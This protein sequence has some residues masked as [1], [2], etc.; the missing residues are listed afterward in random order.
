[1][2]GACL[3]TPSTSA[4]GGARALGAHHS[5]HH[6]RPQYHTE[7]ALGSLLNVAEMAWGQG[8]DL[9]SCDNYALAASLEF[10]ARL[11]N[12]GNDND[13]LPPGF[14]L[15]SRLPPPPTN[16]TWKFQ[17]GQQTWVAVSTLDGTTF[18]ELGTNV[19]FVVR[20]CWVVRCA[21]LR[22]RCCCF[23]STLVEVV[24]AA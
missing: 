15:S 14:E 24:C 12:A 11:L 22:Y 13:L 3:G 16:T 7:F 10:T 5:R 6:L 18:Q 17:L 8:I 19:Q 23:M 2:P 21:G 20:A 4:L 1:M 9:Y